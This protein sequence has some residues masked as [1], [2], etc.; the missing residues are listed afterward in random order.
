LEEERVQF[1]YILA[2]RVSGYKEKE[3]NMLKTQL[4]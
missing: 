3:T 2:T 1:D 4:M